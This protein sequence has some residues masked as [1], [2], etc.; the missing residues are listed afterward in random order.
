MHLLLAGSTIATLSAWA[1]TPTADVFDTGLAGHFAAALHQADQDCLA[2]SLIVDGGSM[3][4]M[5]DERGGVTEIDLGVMPSIAEQE[6][7]MAMPS[8]FA[9]AMTAISADAM[10]CAALGAADEEEQIEVRVDM[11][12]DG[13]TLV[14]EHNGERRVM[15]LDLDDLGSIDFHKIASEMDEAGIDMHALIGR[16]MNGDA[17]P[18]VKVEMVIE[19]DDEDGNRTRRRMHIGGG[20]DGDQR[21]H[22]MMM[23]MGDEDG[24]W[25]PGRGGHE[26]HERSER[27]HP[28]MDGGHGCPLCGRGG[29]EH[30]GMGDRGDRHEPYGMMGRGDRGHE[31]DGDRGHDHDGDRGH[32][33]DGMRDEDDGHEFFER[34][35]QFDEKIAMTRQVAA[36]LSDQEAMAVF[37]VWQVREHLD[38]M[39]RIEML[40]PMVTDVDLLRS[41]RNAAA[42]V[43]MESYGEIGDEDGAAETLRE[44]IL[45]NGRM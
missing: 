38:P 2:T 31:H 33:H 5:L 25:M 1:V 27:R 17:H 21:D 37:G 34:A 26:P 45:S 10:V 11:G 22:I 7:R 43:V 32:E 3:L 18:E 16:L 13:G 9:G 36:R 24:Q 23:F 29:E 14:I 6:L 8:I 15:E 41:V 40:L 42:F 35:G 39:D 12:N 20:D 19:V 28:D 4:V 44:M 30:R